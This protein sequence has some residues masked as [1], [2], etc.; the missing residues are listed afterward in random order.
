[1]VP[2]DAYYGGG[3]ASPTESDIASMAAG[4]TSGF[5]CRSVTG[6]STRVS[7]HSYGNA[8]D[9]NPFENP[10]ATATTVYPQAA[11]DRYYRDRSLHAAEPGF[12]I[13]LLAGAGDEI[14]AGDQLQKSAAVNDTFS[15]PDILRT[16]P[17]SRAEPPG[18]T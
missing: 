3:T 1:M 17:A 16:G 8:I 6:E 9:I 12:A 4:N 13:V 2:V 5:N 10:Y 15:M 7:Q 11:A 18:E 14:S